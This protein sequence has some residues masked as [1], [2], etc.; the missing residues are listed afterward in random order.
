[1]SL[2]ETCTHGTLKG[3]FILNPHHTLEESA[4][5]APFVSPESSQSSLMYSA[6]FTDPEVLE[7][8]LENLPFFLA[9]LHTKKER[10]RA[11]ITWR[12]IGM[13]G[14]TCKV[15][16]NSFIGFVLVAMDAAIPM[17]DALAVSFVLKQTWRTDTVVYEA[18]VR[19]LMKMMSAKMMST[20][21]NDV[22]AEEECLRI[23]V[24]ER[25]AFAVI[26]SI[27]VNRVNTCMLKMTLHS[28]SWRFVCVTLLYVHSVHL[29]P[30]QFK[31][32]NAHFCTW[33][34]KM[35]GNCVSPLFTLS[36]KLRVLSLIIHSVGPCPFFMNL[37][38]LMYLMFLYT[39]QYK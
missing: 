4:K 16:H 6:K 22:T 5:N 35:R 28:F 13:L 32:K 39:H 23:A 36:V 17:C 14:S 20:D 27:K 15:I 25:G 10:E 9:H 3:S 34:R 8:V 29:Q 18:G 1:M 12:W 37:S 38:S 30:L 21:E 33:Q 2:V 24:W 11:R 31:S 26:A 7:P 19:V